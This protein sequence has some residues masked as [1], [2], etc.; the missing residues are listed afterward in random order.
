MEEDAGGEAGLA[1]DGTDL[2]DEF[3]GDRSVAGRYVDGPGESGGRGKSEA[4]T[5]EEYAEISASR[6]ASAGQ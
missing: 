6:S 5:V 2:W 4:V 3:G 1:E